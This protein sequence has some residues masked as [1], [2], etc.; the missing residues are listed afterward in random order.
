[1]IC[2]ESWHLIAPFVFVLLQIDLCCSIR[3]LLQKITTSNNALVVIGRLKSINVERWVQQNTAEDRLEA[4][5]LR[6]IWEPEKKTFM[7]HT[8]RWVFDVGSNLNISL[9]A[10]TAEPFLCAG[11]SCCCKVSRTFLYW[12]V[13]F[14]LFA[15]AS[16]VSMWHVY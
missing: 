4:Q 14:W 12:L 13:S 2:Y 6:I 7:P 3:K 5:E 9:E 10:S 16:V 11:S 15:F 1:M 8:M